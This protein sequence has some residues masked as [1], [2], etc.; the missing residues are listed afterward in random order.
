MTKIK[1][2]IF[3]Y[4]ETLISEG[5]YDRLKGMEAV[6]ALVAHKSLESSPKVMADLSFDFDDI[7]THTRDFSRELVGFLFFSL[8]PCGGRPVQV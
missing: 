8:K 1:G 5:L 4:G 7:P 3:D 6:L 2:I